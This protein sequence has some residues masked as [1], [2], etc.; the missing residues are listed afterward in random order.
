[1]TASFPLTFEPDAHIYR[2]RGEVRPSVTQVLKD[3]KIS[4][5]Y[6][7]DRG[8][9]EFGTAVHRCCQLVLLDRL[10]LDE[11]SPVLHPYVD[12]FRRVR[13]DYR[14]EPIAT[15]LAVYHEDLGYAGTLD[16]HCRVFGKDHAIIDYK[17]GAPPESTALQTAAYDLA[18]SRMQGFPSRSGRRRF[19]MRLLTDETKTTGKTK[20][21]EFTDPMDAEYFK[22]I[23][24][25]WKYQNRK[26][27]RA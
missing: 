14:L 4:P 2:W 9:L 8:W 3:M 13:D 17:T 21:T 26:G 27:V 11:T 23:L 25:H 19:A 1:M 6:P 5:S 18:L 10:D 7:P 24:L 12:A 16:L 15:E 22:G 20:L